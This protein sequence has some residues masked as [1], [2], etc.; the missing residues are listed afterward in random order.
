[1]FLPPVSRLDHS[2]DEPPQLN[3]TGFRNE[4]FRTGSNDHFFPILQPCVLRFGKVQVQKQL[5]K[6]RHTSS[7]GLKLLLDFHCHGHNNDRLVKVRKQPHDHHN[8]L[9]K[10]ES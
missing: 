4:G 7:F 8:G 10:A 5:D 3:L 9:K 1:M 2:P 6:C